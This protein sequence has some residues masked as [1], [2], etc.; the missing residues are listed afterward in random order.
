MIPM[1]ATAT[2]AAPVLKPQPTRTPIAPPPPQ[3]P[4]ENGEPNLGT[5]ASHMGPWR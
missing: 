1:H 3:N 4:P 5:L 2:T